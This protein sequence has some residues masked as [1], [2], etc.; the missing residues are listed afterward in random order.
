MGVWRSGNLSSLL[1]SLASDPAVG[2]RF[3]DFRSVQTD[4][5]Y[6][7]DDGGFRNFFLGAAVERP[8]ENFSEPRTMRRFQNKLKPVVAAQP[9]ERRCGRAQNLHAVAFK[10]REI[11][12]KRP[13]P[14]NGVLH[15]AVADQNRCERRERRIVQ[16]ATEVG[17][18]VVERNIV[19][20]CGILNRVVLRIVGLHE[21]FARKFAAP[22][23]AGDLR[24]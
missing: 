2:S 8:G 6:V 24:E 14:A 7:N 22:G 21:H 13:R 5:V 16:D 19:L 4:G 20:L 17:F 3:P 15:L 11:S 18:L 23:A 10:W 9:G 12:G 1:Y